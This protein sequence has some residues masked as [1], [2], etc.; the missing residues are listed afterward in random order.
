MEKTQ[1][2]QPEK[3]SKCNN[4]PEDIL[5]LACGHDLCLLCAA[6]V[7]HK[8]SEA[9]YTKQTNVSIKKYLY[10]PLNFNKKGHSM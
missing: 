2:D 7:F 5:M 6:K 4:F 3:C 10:F 1:S 8:A 9:K